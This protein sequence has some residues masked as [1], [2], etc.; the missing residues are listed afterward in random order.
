MNK[1]TEPTSRSGRWF[2]DHWFQL[3][4]LIAIAAV[5]NYRIDANERELNSVKSH[6]TTYARE[7]GWRVD[8]LSTRVDRLESISEKQATLLIEMKS[9][10]RVV[11]EWVKEQKARHP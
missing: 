11:A 4:L 10:L 7:T 1:D 8:G 9:D 6:G 3:A 2:A 5:S